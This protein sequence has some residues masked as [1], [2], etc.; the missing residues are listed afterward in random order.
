MYTTIIFI[1]LESCLN[2]LNVI[3]ITISLVG[4]KKVYNLIKIFKWYLL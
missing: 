3:I 2:A 1:V 4:P